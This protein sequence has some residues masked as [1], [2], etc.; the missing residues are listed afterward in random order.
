MRIALLLAAVFS[1]VGTDAT[2]QRMAPELSDLCAPT[3][4]MMN[5]DT[6]LSQIELVKV[7]KCVSWVAGY[8]EA[9]GQMSAFGGT[10]V[11]CLPPDGVNGEIAI[12]LVMNF[13]RAHPEY[14][15]QTARS[16]MLAALQEFFPCK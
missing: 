2:A 3:V 4:R 14:Q 7:N 10:R 13:M 5:G 11:V 1:F 12:R 8:L 6:T 15:N 16:N 9:V